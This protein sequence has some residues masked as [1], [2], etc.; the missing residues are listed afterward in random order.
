MSDH[1]LAKARELSAIVDEDEYNLLIDLQISGSVDGDVENP[2]G[3]VR[4][5]IPNKQSY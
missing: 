5:V 4:G 1:P 2:R 3:G